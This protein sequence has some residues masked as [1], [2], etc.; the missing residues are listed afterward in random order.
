MQGYDANALYPWCLMQDQLYGELN[1]EENT[2]QINLNLID[3]ILDDS[4]LEPVM[5]IS[6]YLRHYIINLQNF[7]QSF[8]IL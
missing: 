3:S 1:Y 8:I 2:G 5:L 4:F 6:K 7:L